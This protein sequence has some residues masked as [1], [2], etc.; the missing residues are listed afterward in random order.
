MY[1]IRHEW[2][3]ADIWPDNTLLTRVKTA[4]DVF[5]YVYDDDD[6]DD[7]DVDD[8]MMVMMMVMRVVMMIMLTMLVAMVMVEFMMGA[9]IIRRGKTTLWWD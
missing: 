2:K 8:M 5:C 6:D 9:M 1:H 3:L 7:D 4:A